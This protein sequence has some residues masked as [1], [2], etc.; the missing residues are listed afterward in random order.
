MKRDLPC[1][2]YESVNNRSGFRY[3]VGY[4]ARLKNNIKY[5][6]WRFIARRK[7]AI[8][9]ANVV[10]NYKLAKNAN[11]NLKIGDNSS[12][13]TYKID[14]R[15]PVTIGSN[16]LIGSAEIITTSH[17]IDSRTFDRKDYGIIIEDYVW[18]ATNALILPSCRK[19]EY[20][21]VVSAGA[22]VVRNVSSKS[23]VSG[24]PAE[25]FKKRSVVHDHL[26]T[27]SLRGG[28]FNAYRIAK[29]K[30]RTNKE[31]KV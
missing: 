12:I 10:I 17:N 7:G 22:V 6:F 3:Y 9:G 30:E 24:N 16:C 5:A 26:V 29:G 20:G 27:E 2:Y 8:V 11:A 23:V 31:N 4:L 13:A 15:N 18:I 25:E 21:A 14:L 28:D 19:I 1:E